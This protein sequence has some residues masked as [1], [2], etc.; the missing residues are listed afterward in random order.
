MKYKFLGGSRNWVKCNAYEYN[1]VI[2]ECFLTDCLWIQ[3]WLVVTWGSGQSIFISQSETSYNRKSEVWACENL[4]L[5]FSLCFASWT[6]P[7][8]SVCYLLSIRC[9]TCHLV[10]SIHLTFTKDFI[11][12]FSS[13][14]Q[15]SPLQDSCSV[16]IE[17]SLWWPVWLTGRAHSTHQITN[18][19]IKQWMWQQ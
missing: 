15:E 1:I 8:T 13:V 10:D 12:S 4:T 18:H 2:T 6:L 16:G 19:H 5:K 9:E 17:W 11:S 7:I 3:L 14:G